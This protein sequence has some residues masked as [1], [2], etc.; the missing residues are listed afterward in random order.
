MDADT[1]TWL[2]IRYRVSNKLLVLLAWLILL[3]LITPQ[4]VIVPLSFS[5]EAYLS[6][7]PA[8]WSTKWYGSFANSPDWGRAAINSLAIGLPTAL[9]SMILGTMASLAVSRGGITR[10]S[11]VAALMVAPMML[12][13]II[14][15]IGLYPIM[16][17]FKL[18][19]SYAG[20]IIAHTVVGIPLVF[21][22]VNSALSRHSGSLELAAMT[23]GAG[24]W[25]SFWK[26]TFPL[27]RPGI[28]IGGILAFA[29]SFDELMLALFLTG[30]GTQT[31]PRLI[32]LQMNDYL[33]PTIAAAASLIFLVTL[34]LLV[35]VSILQTRSGA[36]KANAHG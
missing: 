2:P 9:L 19:T 24:P 27:I 31:L 11:L 32:W 18:L 23:L 26:V 8:G 30:V 5:S 3:F 34:G 33:T 15:A 1:A 10:Q 16:L 17:W 28:L 20:V 12:P 22:T 13:H 25:Q 35:T 21:I 7:P 6:F 29:S 4:F 14:L 36:E